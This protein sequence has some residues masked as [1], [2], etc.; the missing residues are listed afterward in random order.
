M[1][2]R[3]LSLYL[4]QVKPQTPN[5]KPRTDMEHRVLSLYL[6]QVKP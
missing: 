5:P 1:E 6:A 2:H 4:A 3:V